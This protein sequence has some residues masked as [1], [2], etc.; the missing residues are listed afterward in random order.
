VGKRKQG[1]EEGYVQERRDEHS[2]SEKSKKQQER[3]F[4]P[5]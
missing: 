5:G 4:V 2:G 3:T 1:R